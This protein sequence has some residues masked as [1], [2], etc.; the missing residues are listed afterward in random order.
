MKE[1]HEQGV[2][3]Q[4]ERTERTKGRSPVI[5]S[6]THARRAATPPAR[7]TNALGIVVTSV[8]C[9]ASRLQQCAAHN[10]RAGWPSHRLIGPRQADAAEAIGEVFG[11]VL[12]VERL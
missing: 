11:K 10:R 2:A 3:N 6:A 1:P 12:A 9:A 8:F 7:I 4:F 5:N